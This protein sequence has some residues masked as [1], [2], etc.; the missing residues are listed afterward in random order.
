MKFKCN[1]CFM[2]FEGGIEEAREHL[3]SHFSDKIEWLDDD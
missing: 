1:I 3:M 2:T